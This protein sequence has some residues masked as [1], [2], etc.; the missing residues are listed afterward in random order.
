MSAKIS[1][2]LSLFYVGKFRIAGAAV[3]LLLGLAGIF[4]WANSSPPDF[5]L[6]IVKSGSDA[7][8]TWT[9]TDVLLQSSQT[10]N[11]DWTDL[12]AAT[13]PY[14]VPINMN[15]GF[16]RL[17]KLSIIQSIEPAF[18]PPT[19]GTLY[20]L[21]RNFTSDST[22]LL[23]GLPAGSVTFVDSTLLSVSVG[24]MANGNY[25]VSV[26]NLPTGPAN[27]TVTNALT[28][29]NAPLASLEVTPGM[30]EGRTASGEINLTHVDLQID[31]PV[32]P[33]FVIARTH[34]SRHDAAGS[35]F[36][37][38]WDFSC[39]ISVAMD[40]ADVVVNDG[41]GRSDK[42]FNQPN[43]TFRRAEFF[44]EGS[45]SA[46]TFTL[47][48]AD[49]GRWVFRPLDAATAPG[50]IAQ[51]ID[52]NGNTMTYAY[53]GTGQLTTVTDALNRAVQFAYNGSGQLT[54]V[55]DFAGRTVTY[56]YYGAAE[57]GGSE[58]DL[59][60]MTSPAV[61]GT[62]NGN[63]FPLGKT[64]TYTYTKGFADERLNHNLTGVI[65]NTGVQ[66]QTI[67]Y[68]TELNPTHFD[69]D[70]AVSV[71]LGANT[72]TVFSCEALS[73]SPA[74]RYAKTKVTVNDPV[75]NVS[76]TLYDSKNRPLSIKELTGRATP[77]TPVTASGNQPTGKLRSSD[78]AYF[79]TT[80]AYN[81]DS[82]VTRITYP[83]GNSV[84]MVYA[85]DL[86]S[87]TPVRERGNLRTRT[88]TPAPGVPSD[89]AQRVDQ[90]QYQ[91][92][93]GTMECPSVDQNQGTW[94]DDFGDSSGIGACVTTHTDPRGNVTNATYDANGNCLS[95]SPPGLATGHSFEYNAA[96][97]L[98]AHVS[99]A[100]ANARRKRDTFNYYASG[101]QQGYLQSAV[102][103]ANGL[104][105]TTTYTH[106]SVGNIT[107]AVDAR[108]NDSQFVY[109]QLNQLMQ[110]KSAPG[111]GGVRSQ[112]DFTYNA[113]IAVY[114][115]KKA[116]NFDADTSLSI[117]FPISW[118]VIGLD[119]NSPDLVRKDVSNFD[120]NGNPIGDGTLTTS[121]GRDSVGRVT[122]VTDEVSGTSS[123]VTQFQYD[124]A[125]QVTSVLSPLAVSGADAFN[126]VATSYDERG[127]PFQ[128]TA[129]P[130]SPAQSTTQFAYDANAN[131]ATLT[132]GLEGTPR[133]TTVV[134]DGFADS[135]SAD[136]AIRRGGR[137]LVHLRERIVSVDLVRRGGRRGAAQPGQVSGASHL[138]I[139]GGGTGPITGSGP[140]NAG[141]WVEKLV[142]QNRNAVSAPDPITGSG[143]S[144]SADLK[145]TLPF[146]ADATG[147][148]GVNMLSPDWRYTLIVSDN[149]GNVEHGSNTPRGSF[150]RDE[151]PR[152]VLP[153]KFLVGVRVC[154]TQTSRPR[155]ITDPQGNITTG[156]YGN[157][158]RTYTKLSV[159]PGVVTD[160][161]GNIT[162]FHYDANGNCSSVR[163]DGEA[164]D[165]PGSAGNVKLAEASYQYDALNR[166]TSR[167]N[168]LLDASGT[169][170][171]SVTS[172]AA[173]ADNG[174]TTAV[175]DAL[176]HVTTVAYDF[177]GRVSSVTD[178]K[179]NSVAYAYDAN[180][181]VTGVTNTLKSDLGNADLVL[182]TTYAYD[183]LNRC[184]S[185][186]DNVGNTVSSAY[187]SRGNVVRSTDARGIVSQYQYDGL[188]RLTRSGRDMNNNGSTLDPV[189]IVTTN[190][191]D[192]NS[193]LVS[194]TDPNG[195]TSGHTYDAL[196]RVHGSFDGDFATTQCSYD[197]HG[198]IISTTDSN[199]TLVNY[200]YDGNNR[201][202]QKVIIPA[203]GVATT[204]TLEQY[205]YDGLSRVIQ[206]N[207]N[208]ATTSFTYDSL[209]R[210]LTETQSGR[211]VT[212]TYDA[213]GNLLTLAYPGGRQLGYTYDAG[214]L[215]TSVSLLATTDG[216]TLGVLNTN[217][218]LGGLTE[219]VDNRNNTR[220][221]TTYLNRCYLPD[222]IRGGDMITG[223]VVSTVQTVNSVSNAVIEETTYSY[224]AA[225][226]QTGKTSSFPGQVV[227]K[228]YQYDPADRLVNTVVTTN[229]VPTAN[230]TYT[231]DKAGNRLNVTGDN[232]PGL[233][234]LDN[235]LPEPA[236]FQV[237]QYTTTP[238]GDFTYDKNGNRLAESVL[239]QTV[240]TFSYDYANQLTGITA[241]SAGVTTPITV[242]N[243]G[244][245][246][247]AT[248]PG[249]FLILTPTGWTAYNPNGILNGNTNSI[250][251]IRPNLG[252]T[253]YPGGTTEGVNAA[254]V[255]LAGPLVPGA[256]A[257]LQQTLA[258]PLQANTNY[259]LRVDVGNI[260]S[261]TSGPG[262]SDGGGVFYNLNGFPGYRIELL[263]GAVVVAQDDNTLGGTIPEGQFVTST[264]NFNPG[265]VH[266]Q[267]GQ[268]LTIR[269]I[270]LK[271]P[272]T[273]PAPGIEVN[274]DNVRLTTT[275][276]P[277]LAPL[278]TYTY[279]ALG[280]RIQKAVINGVVTTTTNFVYDGGNVIEERDGAG[281]SSSITFLNTNVQIMTT[282]EV[283]PE[284]DGCG[285]RVVRRNG[286]NY[287]PHTDGA[288]STVALT[289]DNGT[290][291]ERYAYADFGEPAFLDGSGASIGASAVGNA[292]LWGGMQYDTENGFYSSP[293]LDPRTGS[294]IKI[295]A[296]RGG[297]VIL[298]PLIY[299][300]S[301]GG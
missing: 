200:T 152:G 215:C 117:Q 94:S 59:K 236:D 41:S 102:A 288:G 202:T 178:A 219:R 243:A 38:A 42:F 276:A 78:P 220:T 156:C 98:T 32:G 73:P 124:A 183:N 82:Q 179:N 287:W 17:R 201:L 16:F 129:A 65:D 127:L 206:A 28:V 244:F 224:D 223:A 182:A 274:F 153:N 39:N 192:A 5:K 24:A 142:S 190:S 198:N 36:D 285:N 49:K 279:D 47:T 205:S 268:P 3:V 121:Y 66:V 289:L 272:G 212:S 31:C 116:A 228:V 133:T 114:N 86:S 172:S 226:N 283:D 293:Y 46:S 77:G 187:D 299:D 10:L 43:G 11:G 278:A 75:G 252:G 83:R 84:A 63:D 55:T 9:D 222:D 203:V 138:A 92:G 104:A 107:N 48:F 12:P 15:R 100:D 295:R 141:L 26:V 256:V 23:D 275:A 145:I 93:F 69:F 270:N 204:T 291:A 254:L 195:N 146:L 238:V 176:G 144:G 29:E 149:Y 14:T 297:S 112:T 106:D 193:R 282:I 118:D 168:L 247:N 245:E 72:A 232:H 240:R 271:A 134:A 34:R 267:L 71:A 91:P 208:A 37:T 44:R 284:I 52:R 50:K 262:S 225:L 22:V 253:F 53:N 143:P 184:T 241:L 45:L 290:V 54:G 165:V 214:N 151:S 115:A 209:G 207:N 246:A 62:P 301:G 140:S 155:S 97:Q 90:W 239:G 30:A 269:L 113:L 263:A 58:G 167:T 277:V 188:S 259:T 163:K 35:P 40:G 265:A 132:E 173:Y 199:G 105:L 251:V 1:K 126:T 218:Y 266:A 131:L 160:P 294:G 292:Y 125:G 51:S 76:E 197:A 137:L 171:G 13:S 181:N 119:S 148:S 180:G 159:H 128:Q 296:V 8:L 186:M 79:E 120:E 64:I 235:T 234:T 300:K 211:T 147:Q 122:S 2:V 162:T 189:D 261:G 61:T 298:V 286:T 257:G 237:N 6:G 74:N 108:G 56:A 174:A 248:P 255:Y 250:G 210:K 101:A 217:H 227:A 81:L 177:A 80:L 185:S 19:G 150:G 25:D 231:L 111:G 20:V 130:G 4:G 154:N 109:N 68:T 70:R 233:Y 175:T 7:L 103:D 264:I 281:V 110:V 123:T 27:A 216:D 158:I 191:Y 161:L 135:G 194:K 170:T 18:L 96:G 57:P 280:R 21:G 258:A 88:Q 60:S 157:Q 260:A 139:G 95:I 164:N 273:V 213:A 87:A 99:P 221:F 249:A 136:L 196:N 166:L 230:I 242:N 229:A 169:T 85:G 33:D 67:A 89:Q